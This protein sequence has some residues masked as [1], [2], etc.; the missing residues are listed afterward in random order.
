MSDHSYAK[1]QSRLTQTISEW[2]A[3][4]ID[5]DTRLVTLRLDHLELS[6]DLSRVKVCCYHHDDLDGL[7]KILNKHSHAVQKHI[8]SNMKIRRTPSVKF[9]PGQ[10]H[11]PQQQLENILNELSAT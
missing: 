5:I 3:L 10:L 7:L 6:R 4:N 11:S 8:Y 1:I 2:I 9:T